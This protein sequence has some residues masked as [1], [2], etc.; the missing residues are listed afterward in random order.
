MTRPDAGRRREAAGPEGAT[1]RRGRRAVAGAAAVWAAAAL[2]GPAGPASADTPGA[3]AGPGAVTVPGTAAVPGKGAAPGTAVLPGA[4]AASPSAADLPAM[5][6]T[7]PD[8]RENG[9]RKP[10]TRTTVDRAPWAQVY[11][12]PESVWPLGRGAGVTV[13]VLGSGTDASAGTGSGVLAGRLTFGPRLHGQGDAGR[14]CVGHGTFLAGL[15]AGRR[16]PDSGPAG[17]AP[18]ATV[19][20]VAVTD[21]AG[22]TT[23]DLLA[24][25]IRA[26]A[27]GGARVAVVGVPVPAPNQALTDA[28]E[29]AAAK[30]LL[31]VAP[32]GSDGQSAKGGAVFPAGYPGVLAVASIGPGGGPSPGDTGAG[33]GGTGGTGG[34]GARVD[35]AAPGEGLQAAG[36]GGGYFT[37]SGPSGAAAL[38]AGAAALLLSR[39]PGWTPSQVAERLKSTAY[40]PGS[41]LP[42]P[43][44]GWGTLDVVAA[45]T[46]PPPATGAPAAPAEPVTVPPPPDRT[47]LTRASAVAGASAA[48]VAVVA[49]A[50]AVV[51]AGRR[52]TAGRPSQS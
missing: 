43:V 30:G 15:V 31:L 32:A 18:E 50:A 5:S 22:T 39:E 34:T 13:A 21:D 45:V 36:P 38:V 46:A 41:A 26:A 52:R 35:L 8:V 17:I 10:S 42:D 11:L 33:P 37:A 20:A 2:L 49:L 23:P 44:V 48:L 25:G 19:L 12:R 3:S 29:Y 16:T 7:L 40:R 28:V 24:Q 47:A 51:R 1:V 27:D 14:D 9:C 6:Q 4:A